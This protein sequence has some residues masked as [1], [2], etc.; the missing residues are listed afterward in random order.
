MRPKVAHDCQLSLKRRDCKCGVVFRLALLAGLIA[1]SLGLIVPPATALDWPQRPIM[2]VL[3]YPPGGT[4]DF[5]ARI[6]GARLSEKLGQPVIV[7][8]K[9]GA[10]E[11][12]AT[13][14]VIHARPDGYTLYFASSAQTTSVPMTEKVNYQ[15]S[16]LTLISASGNGP[17]ILAVSSHLPVHTLKE[18]IDYAKANPGK[19]TYSSAGTGSVAH[20]A[21]ALFVARAGIQALHVPYRGAG[22]G[23]AALIGGQVDFDFG[24]SA[25]L[26]PHQHDE[27]IRIIAVSTP[28]RMPQLP[29]VPAV[30]EVIPGFTI[31]AW[32]GFLGPAHL[33]QPIVDRLAKEISSIAK[34]PDIVAKLA[35]AG[36]EATSTTPAQ[37]KEI[38]QN[39]QSVYAEA[40]KAAG[41]NHQ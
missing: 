24:N 18:F 37:F 19:L 8:S 6:I 27:H 16:D 29:D 5:Q 33:P 22:P 39:E 2:L 28:K 10:A 17:M 12:V 1:A 4:I 23:A 20:L 7:Q 38:I 41:L 30:S 3:P 26:L 21:G 11:I 32:Q 9:P 13:E 36:V 31:T 34:E 25:D 14:Y 15:L 35:T 40:V